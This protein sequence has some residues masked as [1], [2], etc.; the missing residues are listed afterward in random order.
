MKI[1]LL[2]SLVL[3]AA[4]AA[5]GVNAQASPPA[6]LKIEQPWARPTV[7]G[8]HAGGAYLTLRNDAAT[9]DRLLGGSTPVAERV[10]VHEMRMDGNVMRMRELAAL[11]VPAGKPTKLEPGGMHLMLMGLKAPLKAGDK[12]PLK[13]RFEKAGEIETVL[14]VQTRPAAATDAHKH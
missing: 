10:E 9:P 2:Q 7:A 6:V 4:M 5:P 1:H 13:L 14:V 8:Q 3:A 12:V 11:E